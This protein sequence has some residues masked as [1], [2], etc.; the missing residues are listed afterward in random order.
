MSGKKTGAK[1]IA[2]NARR[3][4]ICGSDKGMIHRFGINT[5]RRCFKDIAEKLGF[6]K[7]G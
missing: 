7:M 1:K 4:R 5:C 6:R 3:C 2:K